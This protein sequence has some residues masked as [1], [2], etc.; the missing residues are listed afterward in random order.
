MWLVKL[1]Q[2]VQKWYPLLG[3]FND[4]VGLPLQGNNDI[5]LTGKYITYKECLL[6]CVVHVSFLTFSANSEY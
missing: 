1:P 3:F 6:V 4:D 5:Y 2:Q